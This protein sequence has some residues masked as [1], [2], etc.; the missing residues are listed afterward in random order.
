MSA[1]VQFYFS[2]EAN[3]QTEQHTGTGGYRPTLQRKG[4][5]S[6]GVVAYSKT[7]QYLAWS[8]ERF[9]MEQELSSQQT[10]NNRNHI[11]VLHFKIYVMALYS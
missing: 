4:A 1:S 3:H 10:F 11:N 6:I 5:I 2:C 7:G 8:G 9:N